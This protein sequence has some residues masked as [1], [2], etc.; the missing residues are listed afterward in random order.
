MQ[1][2]IEKALQ[3][4]ND[5]I[6]SLKTLS[7]KIGSPIIAQELIELL[8]SNIMEYKTNELNLD[9]IE[10]QAAYETNDCQEQDEIDQEERLLVDKVIAISESVD[11]S[12]SHTHNTQEKKRKLNHS[13]LNTRAI[14]MTKDFELI[15][16]ITT[17]VPFI[18]SGIPRLSEFDVKMAKLN[19]KGIT[20]KNV[21]YLHSTKIFQG[22]MDLRIEI[23]KYYEEN[24]NSA[25]DASQQK[26]IN[27]DDH[28]EKAIF[29]ED[30]LINTQIINPSTIN[31]VRENKEQIQ[32][33]DKTKS[34]DFGSHRKTPL[35]N[36]HNI[37]EKS[38]NKC[39]YKVK[40]KQII[41]LNFIMLF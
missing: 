8:V 40:I 28:N 33:V 12:Q 25:L 32:W 22:N 37:F 5:A 38:P 27:I 1:N 3:V 18:K 34:K 4:W 29:I 26:N 13:K 6:I 16:A 31:E 14:I 23:L 21:Q 9:E 24:L 35:S 10:V 41:Y 2:D 36:N 20:K 30:K 19:E 15:L 7:N 17:L 39:N 11:R